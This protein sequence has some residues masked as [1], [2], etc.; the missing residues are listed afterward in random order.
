MPFDW[1]IATE[2]EHKC[3]LLS[4]Y[5]H[6]VMFIS[7]TGLSI[8]FLNTSFIGTNTHFFTLSDSVKTVI[9]SSGFD[10][11]FVAIL[12]GMTGTFLRGSYRSM[13]RHFFFF[14]TH[15]SKGDPRQSEHSA[16]SWYS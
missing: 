10:K 7:L 14:F 12:L 11:W 3:V 13:E 2:L 5:S 15:L 8:A 4:K 16:N 6:P 9:S 1:T